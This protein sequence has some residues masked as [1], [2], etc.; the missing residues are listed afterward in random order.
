MLINVFVLFL[1]TQ[2]LAITTG[3]PIR[4]TNCTLFSKV[5]GG[6]EAIGY[7]MALVYNYQIA[8]QS[9]LSYYTETAVASNLFQGLQLAG[10]SGIYSPLML[11][12]SRD[13]A[14]QN[15][16]GFNGTDLTGFFSKMH[17][18]LLRD[19]CNWLLSYPNQALTLRTN[20]NCSHPLEQ[21]LLSQFTYLVTKMH[22][23]EFGGFQEQFGCQHNRQFHL[24]WLDSFKNQN[25]YGTEMNY[26][27]GLIYSRK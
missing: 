1:L 7:I 22:H 15:Y 12:V 13:P 16:R 21:L 23:V 27:E 25:D 18:N 11:R 6:H 3:V 5:I 4:P 10:V 20:I 19:T 8:L 17:S 14:L 24:A 2:S 9:N 26:L